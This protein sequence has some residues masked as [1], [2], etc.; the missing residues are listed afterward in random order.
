MLFPHRF[1]GQGF[2]T[3]VRSLETAYALSMS[4]YLIAT[5]SYH[6]GH[7]EGTEYRLDIPPSSGDIVSGYL[8]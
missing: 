8:P 7:T 2:S 5:P 4:A 1:A 3:A 6:L